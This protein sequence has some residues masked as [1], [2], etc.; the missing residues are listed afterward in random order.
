MKKQ[1]GIKKLRKT[2]VKDETWK[3]HGDE[4]HMNRFPWQLTSVYIRDFCTNEYSANDTIRGGLTLDGL[5][6]DRS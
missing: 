1:N 4:E 2:K 3:E 6:I 5:D